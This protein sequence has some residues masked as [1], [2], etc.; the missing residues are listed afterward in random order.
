MQSDKAP[1][2]GSGGRCDRLRRQFRHLDAVAAA[3]GATRAVGTSLGAGAIALGLL[4][5]SA[6]SVY[7]ASVDFVELRLRQAMG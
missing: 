2:R 7:S 1:D 5:S 6:L 4:L 3:Y